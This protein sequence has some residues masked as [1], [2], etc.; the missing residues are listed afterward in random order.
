MGRAGHLRADPETGLKG[1]RLRHL[2][3]KRMPSERGG[4]LIPE[5][6][7]APA[8]VGTRY[9]RAARY[10]GPSNAQVEGGLHLLRVGDV[11]HPHYVRRN[12]AL[13]AAGTGT[14][15]PRRLRWRA[16]APHRSRR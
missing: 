2:C 8:P 15:A 11:G 7:G 12:A 4:G 13:T 1:C 6:R 16:R 10:D 14:R 3:P 5:E 9:R